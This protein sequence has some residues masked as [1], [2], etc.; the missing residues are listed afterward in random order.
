MIELTNLM[1]G[2]YVLCNGKVCRVKEV[3]GMACVA[4]IDNEEEF[5]CNAED[6]QPIP[7]TDEFL[8]KN[9]FEHEG[10]AGYIY[11]NQMGIMVV[12]SSFIN[13][14]RLRIIKD[15]N[16]LYNSQD[17]ADIY[18]HIL[19]HALRLCQIDKTIEL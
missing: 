8:E 15:L 18:V 7:L 19:Q 16:I 11:D 14:K 4:P 13:I 17:F 10:V 12:Y 3:G 1:K 5:F 2:D 6:I 9:G